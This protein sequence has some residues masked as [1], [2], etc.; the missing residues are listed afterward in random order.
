[1]TTDEFKRQYMGTFEISQ[2][3]IDLNNKLIEYYD[4]T[5]GTI[6]NHD[7]VKYWKEFKKWALDRNY[8]PVEISRAN[9]HIGRA[10]A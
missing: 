3:D 10:Y 4:K 9:R 5:K 1:M 2:R 8:E 6:S 7:A